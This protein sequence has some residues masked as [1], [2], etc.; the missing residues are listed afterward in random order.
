MK[1]TF[2][3]GQKEYKFKKDAVTH[4]RKILNSYNFDESLSASDI[5]DVNALID[6]SYFNELVDLDLEDD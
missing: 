5:E 6:Y 2:K 3:I 4:Y 1:K